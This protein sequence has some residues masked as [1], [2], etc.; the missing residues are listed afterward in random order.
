MSEK[1]LFK[2]SL[3]RVFAF[4]AVISFIGLTVS[5]SGI[6]GSSKSKSENNKADTEKAYV[7]SG[8]ILF[9]GG[10]PAG[11]AATTS[12]AIEDGYEYSLKVCHG[13]KNINEGLISWDQSTAKDVEIT[14]EAGVLSYEVKLTNSGFWK[15]ELFLVDE[16]AN[17]SKK[18]LTKQIEISEDYKPIICDLVIKPSF[19]DT[20]ATTPDTSSVKLDVYK[21]MGENPEDDVVKVIWTWKE[22]IVVADANGLPESVSK[23]I[24]PWFYS[25]K[26]VQKV[27]EAN[28]QKVTFEFDNVPAWSYE[29]ELTFV[30][31]SGE[32]FNIYEPI[33][34]F[35]DFVTD[36]WHGSLDNN[37]FIY[38]NENEKYNFVVT[39][40][41]LNTAGESIVLYNYYED[42][43][44]QKSG[45]KYYLTPDVNLVNPSQTEPYLTTEDENALD[46]CFDSAGNVYFLK[47]Q[48]NNGWALS[49]EFFGGGEYAT[50]SMSTPNTPSLIACDQVNNNLYAMYFYYGDEDNKNKISI[51]DLTD[52]LYNHNQS[53]YQITIDSASDV[54]NIT[55][56]DFT[57]V[58]FV[59][60]NGI[61]YIA[62]AKIIKPS[63]NEVTDDWYTECKIIAIQLEYIDFSETLSDPDNDIYIYTYTTAGASDTIC[64]QDFADTVAI[65]DMLCQDGM[66]YLLVN[67]TK[68]S[69]L[70]S[71]NGNTY[72]RGGLFWY[73]LQFDGA[74]VTVV[75]RGNVGW[76]PT[77]DALDSLKMGVAVDEGILY[78]ESNNNYTP[79]IKTWD[80]V[81]YNLCAPFNSLN[82]YFVGPQKIIAIKPKKLVIADSGIA[83]Y[84]DDDGIL[85]YKDVN[86]IVYIDLEEITE[87]S[88]LPMLDSMDMSSQF[89][90]NYPSVGN[91]TDSEYVNLALDIGGEF[92]IWNPAE[93]NYCVYSETDVDIYPVFFK[94]NNN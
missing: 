92:Y 71:S 57:P 69:Y 32:Y 14:E 94:D 85:K 89:C 36:S 38:D 49:S 4:V 68:A 18:I 43:T 66:L 60:D 2:A 7:V 70:A 40:Y 56:S 45:F 50:V 10:T 44:N 6:G 86:R 64:T 65:N 61:V 19:L 35:K 31:E 55:A 73:D 29:V 30:T 12:F 20:T 79:R 93:A 48:P 33:N 58:D 62:F 88:T 72:S 51:Y 75:S 25:Q 17:V 13:V 77:T 59:V 78:G 53:E 84:T 41:Y 76:A 26:P 28:A 87:S 16:T 11:R 23:L 91:C 74:L 34:V 80:Y 82:E 39:P 42:N 21:D 27:F 81:N 22:P 83:F 5:C 8:K 9:E 47:Q 52:N 15:F 54:Y 3:V 37:H 90:K 46:F 67:S 63:G 24:G 1:K